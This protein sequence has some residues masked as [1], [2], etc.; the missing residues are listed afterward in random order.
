VSEANTTPS[1]VVGIDL[2]DRRSQLVVLDGTSGEV[3]E[4]ST[5]ATTIKGFEAR[6]GRGDPARI[7][8][9]AGTHSRWIRELLRG[10]GHEVIVADPRKVRL[11]ST[12]DSKND[13]NDAMRLALLARADPRLL[14]PI[15][16]RGPEAQ[17][18]LAVLRARDQA[19]KMRT[20]LVNHMRGMVKAFGRR[21]PSCSAASFHKSARD[22]VPRELVPALSSLFD[23]LAALAVA[24]KAYDAKVKALAT[25]EF[26]ETGALQQVAGVG[27]LT[28][29]AF[30][31]TLES[32][33]RFANGR[34]VG[35]FV[36]L[37]PRQKESGTRSPQLGITKAG[38]SYL[39]KLLVGSA[40]YVLGPFGPDCDLRRW[41][42]RLCARGGKNGKK[43]AVVA[44]ARK[45]AVLLHKL[46]LTGEVYEPLR[47]A[48]KH[49]VAVTA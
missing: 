3:L 36:G 41:G 17:T 15:Q 43:R 7:A 24:I 45:L 2:G 20:L 35:A 22:H 6:F 38:D 4:E 46:W 10:F 25:E 47:N 12:S 30:V 28:A 29:L 19:V 49:A 1:L 44:V 13:K 23:V 26:P 8:F 11:I 27:P 21:L 16:H 37:V 40:H 39:R 14:H 42:E 34:V 31:L 48:Q 18:A 9:E 32:P 33:H 5:L